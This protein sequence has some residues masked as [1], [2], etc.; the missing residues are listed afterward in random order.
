[1]RDD[2]DEDAFT[3]GALLAGR[4]AAE[5][6]GDDD[7]AARRLGAFTAY[8]DAFVAH[9]PRDDGEAVES[10]LL[11]RYFSF[12][13]LVPAE[14]TEPI[15]AD[16]EAALAHLTQGAEPAEVLEA[17]W[18]ALATA[19]DASNAGRWVEDERDL[20]IITVIRNV[21]SWGRGALTA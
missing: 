11:A 19:E 2:G 12:L 3:L 14:T 13:P 10:L 16:L 9:V 7:E 5:Q 15:R 8:A 18:R 6:A 1:M 4:E 21:L 17:L 20:P